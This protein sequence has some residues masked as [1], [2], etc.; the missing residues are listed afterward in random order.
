MFS[1]TDEEAFESSIEKYLLEEN[2]YIKGYSKDFN[3]EYAIDEVGLFDFLE[4]TQ[5]Y[6]LDK[7]KR[8]IDYKQKIVFQLS[9]MISKYS[10]LKILKK[11][12]SVADA[13]FILFY[14]A[15]IASSG[16]ETRNLDKISLV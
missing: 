6:E 8:D 11:G 14:P 16:N 2:G 13:N 5:K 1:K 9:K 15:P 10:V 7:P 12:L 4:I 3:K